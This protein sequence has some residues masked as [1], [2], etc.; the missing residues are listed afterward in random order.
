MNKGTTEGIIG[1]GGGGGGG[2]GILES[3]KEYESKY[4]GISNLHCKIC[5][6]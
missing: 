2:I 4:R 3:K 1:G 6:S 5:Q